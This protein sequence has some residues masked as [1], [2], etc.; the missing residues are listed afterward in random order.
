M[1]KTSSSSPMIVEFHTPLGSLN[2]N[3][4]SASK[5]IRALQLRPYLKAKGVEVVLNESHPSAEIAL[6]T[7]WQDDKAYA[8][9]K[10]AKAAGKKVIFDMCVNY[11][12]EAELKNLG[13]V[14]SAKQQEEATRMA[15]ISDVITTASWN[16]RDRARDFNEQ[17]FCLPDSFDLNHFTHT[18]N[19][20]DFDKDKLTVIWSGVSGKAA[21]LEPLYDILG[22]E[23]FNLVLIADKKVK[24]PG[25][26]LFKTRIPT[27]FYRWK[28]ETF[29]RNMIRG[30]VCISYRDLSTAYNKGHSFFKIGIFMCQ[31]VPALASPIPSYEK[32]FDQ[33][34]GKALETLNDWES[35]FKAIK[36]DRQILKTWSG[37]AKASTA[38]YS[39][40]NVADKYVDLFHK[41]RNNDLKAFEDTY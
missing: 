6:F 37:E 18:K 31:G 11:F 15:E 17:A 8:A 12:D 39:T 34:G 10:V 41:M 38:R 2:Y 5:W 23:N 22:A 25:N 27:T 28:Y 3:R 24:I 36:R 14:V 4:T 40:E 35:T 32:L 21:E 29:P 9:A 19:P 7:R 1:T 26:T 16:I 33:G 13:T 30:D 20:D